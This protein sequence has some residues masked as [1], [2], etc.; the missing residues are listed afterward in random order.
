MHIIGMMF[1][2]RDYYRGIKDFISFDKNK[3]EVYTCENDISAK[4]EIQGKGP[5]I[6]CPHEHK[7]RPQGS[8][9]KEIKRKKTVICIK[10]LN[11]TA[12][13]WSFLLFT[14][15]KSGNTKSLQKRNITR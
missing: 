5:W 6:P 2:F 4:E 14:N 9:G 1:F 3:R 10:V 8:S 7:G 11:K 12:A 15:E 13:M